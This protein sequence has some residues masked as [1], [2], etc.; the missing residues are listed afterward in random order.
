VHFSVVVAQQHVVAEGD[1][2]LPL[3]DMPIQ[4]GPKF[5]LAE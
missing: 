3:V 2:G 4:F 5:I 1:S